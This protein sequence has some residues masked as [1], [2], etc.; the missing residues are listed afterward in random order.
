M[1]GGKDEDV[2]ASIF[3]LYT[4]H[5]FGFTKIYYFNYDYK[6]LS[7]IYITLEFP[8]WKKYKEDIFSI[9]TNISVNP[10]EIYGLLQTDKYKFLDV[11]SKT[12]YEGKTG[13]WLVKGHIPTAVNI[14]WKELFVAT[15]S[16]Q[17]KNE[18]IP[19]QTFIE[20]S[21]LKQKFKK[22]FDENNKIIVY[23]NTGS[24][25]SVAYFIMKILFGWKNVK[26]FEKSFGSYQ[27]LHQIC[28]N[29]YPIVKI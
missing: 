15:A 10:D 1:Y 5:K 25:G 28:P 17:D 9:K 6:L 21:A 18:K 13:V 14:F 4:L 3:V 24:E 11:R 19:S 29:Q 26:L 2:Y 8:A 20:I 7:P 16:E 27:Y 23:C 22:Y 12:D